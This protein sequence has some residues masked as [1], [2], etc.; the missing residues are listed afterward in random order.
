MISLF[1]YKSHACFDIRKKKM[2]LYFITE[3][4]DIVSPITSPIPTTFTVLE[5]SINL[6]NF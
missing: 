4:H 1:K 6:Y 2:I 3:I 5:Y